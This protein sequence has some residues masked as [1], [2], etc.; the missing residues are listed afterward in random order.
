MNFSTCIPLSLYIH[1]PWCVRKCPYCDF[2]S[3]TAL[4]MI[5]EKE[6]V[7]ALIADLDEKLPLIKNRCLV[8]IFFGGGTP[9]L[10]S[11]NSIENILSAVHARFAFSPDLE[12]TLEANPGT[13][14]EARFSGFRKAGINRLSIGIQSLQN[15]KLR[16]LGRIHDREYALRAISAGVNAGFVNFNLDFMHGLPAQSIED[17]VADLHDGLQFQPPHLSWYQL[18]IEPNT[19]FHHQPPVLPADEILWDIQEEGKK[20]IHHSGHMQYEISAY[21]IPGK[22]CTHNKN[23][24]EFGDYLGIGAGAHSKITNIEK[25]QITRHWQVKHPNDYLNPK[26]SFTASETI[27]SNE[28][29]IFEFMLNALRLTT[30]VP[31]HLFTERTG[32]PLTSISK[33]IKLAQQKNLLSTDPDRLCATELGLRFLNDLT[34]VFLP[35]T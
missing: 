16:A 17:A 1:L 12:I 7:A 18:T 20:I 26:K 31:M 28:D 34:Q 11:P 10:F 24:W 22:E 32:L 27:V 13:I 29:C 23:Y 25:Q 30:G 4:Q 6:Y 15:E 3:H 14:D 8:S 19:F 21:S 5:P 9:S 33:K 35:S 2:N